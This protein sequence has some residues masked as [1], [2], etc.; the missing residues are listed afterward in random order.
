MNR[1]GWRILRHKVLLTYTKRRWPACFQVMW[2]AVRLQPEA[3]LIVNTPRWDLL[4]RAISH[5]DK[6][7]LCVTLS[8]HDTLVSTFA[9]RSSSDIFLTHSG[10]SDTRPLNQNKHLSITDER[11]L[12]PIFYSMFRAMSELKET[13]VQTCE[14]GHRTCSM[15]EKENGSRQKKMEFMGSFDI[16]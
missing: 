5:P 10:K 7:C 6:H 9:R 16:I 15:L 8:A 11:G 12:W 2:P 3:R 13:A 14:F 1:V 4:P